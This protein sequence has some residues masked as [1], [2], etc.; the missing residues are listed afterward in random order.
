MCAPYNKVVNVSVVS[1]FA[2]HAPLRQPLFWCLL[3]LTLLWDWSRLDH[4]VMALIGTPQGFP[5]REHPLLSK[6][7]H[8]QLKYV[9]EVVFLLMCLMALWPRGLVRDLSR[10]ERWTAIIGM[11]LSLV[12]ISSLKRFSA[13]SCP[14]D[15][16]AFGGMAQPLP[17]WAWGL[18]D[19]GPGHCFPGG[20]ASSAFA[21]LSLAWVAMTA[22]KPAARR[23]GR[24]LFRIILAMGLL[25]GVVQSLRGAHPPAHTIWTGWICAAVGW[26][27]VCALRL[28]R[29]A[30][31]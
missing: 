16:Q 25:M 13:T 4:A 29:P 18:A 2:W 30:S 22:D 15:W 19:G 21:F 9:L 11:T 1:P 14:W 28:R 17:Y 8:E 12:V 27:C 3:V 20:H 10:S 23:W 24:Y 26:V 7:L 31:A 5:L 6:V